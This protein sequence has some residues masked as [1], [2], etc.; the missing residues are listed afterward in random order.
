MFDWAVFHHLNFKLVPT[1]LEEELALLCYCRDNHIPDRSTEHRVAPHTRRDM[2]FLVE[3]SDV[4][5]FISQYE[6]DPVKPRW[7]AGP[8]CSGACSASP[9]SGFGVS[10]A[11]SAI[12]SSSRCLGTRTEISTGMSS[13]TVN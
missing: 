7:L 6:V 5:C 1:T 3:Y 10:S 11:P 8:Y 4:T 2:V 13:R 9:T 12:T